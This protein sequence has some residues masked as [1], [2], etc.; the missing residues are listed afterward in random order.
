MSTAIRPKPITTEPPSP[1]DLAPP[2]TRAELNRTFTQYRYLSGMG[3]ETS[4]AVS[5]QFFMQDHGCEAG[6]VNRA[7]GD[8][9]SPEA[10]AKFRFASDLMG[11]FAER[12]IEHRRRREVLREQAAMR[13]GRDEGT[14]RATPDQIARLREQFAAVGSMN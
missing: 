8:C 3:S 13:E 7:L 11:H 1:L 10:M 2:E 5:I 12:V 9:R 4:F 14:K 6:D